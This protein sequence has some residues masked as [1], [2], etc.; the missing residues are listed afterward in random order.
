MR[1]TNPKQK[2]D[3]IHLST[4]L[5]TSILNEIVERSVIESDSANFY[6]MEIEKCQEYIS[7]MQAEATHIWQAP[8]KPHELENIEDV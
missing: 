4:T 1:S 6:K 2:I 8:T 5:C 3:L 7:L